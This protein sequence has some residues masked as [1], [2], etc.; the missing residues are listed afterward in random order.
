MRI[1]ILALQK[2]NF[3][4]LKR[5]DLRQN[6]KFSIKQILNGKMLLKQ[7]RLTKI[8]SKRKVKKKEKRKIY[9]S[10]RERGGPLEPRSH[11]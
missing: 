11:C 3:K 6:K 8:K 10:V 1:H 4:N 2:Y 9:A 5:H 7:T